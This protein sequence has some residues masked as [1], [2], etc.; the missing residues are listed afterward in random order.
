[1]TKNGAEP[2][3]SRTRNSHPK[4]LQLVPERILSLENWTH[5]RMMGLSNKFEAQLW[6][7]AN[8]VPLMKEL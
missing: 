2:G 8:V 4:E 5:I 7:K 3:R 1:M 6:M